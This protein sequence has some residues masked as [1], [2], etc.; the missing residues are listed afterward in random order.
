VSR[1]VGSD[2]Q[3]IEFLGSITR[4]G[5]QELQIFLFNFTVILAVR[6]LRNAW[7]YRIC[8]NIFDKLTKKIFDAKWCARPS[9]HR[10]SYRALDIRE[11]DRKIR[12]FS[13]LGS[14]PSSEPKT[15]YAEFNCEWNPPN[16][17]RSAYDAAE[18]NLKRAIRSTK[19]SD[20]L[21]SVSALSIENQVKHW[22]TK[23]G[24]FP[25][26]QKHDLD[27]DFNYNMHINT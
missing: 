13:F 4:V 16:R 17:I 11:R 24:K 8:K 15:H 26:W 6:T 5:Y 18:L 20:Q 9:R 12:L 14:V 23:K 25:K 22:I 27:C 7:R 10:K 2:L 21:E 1:S 3:F 19:A